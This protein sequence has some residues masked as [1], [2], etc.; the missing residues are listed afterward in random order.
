MFVP[1]KTLQSNIIIDGMANSYSGRY[2]TRVGTYLTRKYWNRLESIDRS[3]NSNLLV[4]I[5]FDIKKFHNNKTR[6]H[7]SKTFLF[8]TDSPD[9]KLVP[10]E[11]LLILAGK[12]KSLP[13]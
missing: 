10:G 3:K 13:L 9:S 2:S 11:T 5:F 12:A 8:V 4:W 6:F 1:G 7:L